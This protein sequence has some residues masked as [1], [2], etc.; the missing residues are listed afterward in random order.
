MALADHPLL[1]AAARVSG[2]VQH[3]IDLRLPKM[4][5]GAIVRSRMPHARIT[6]VDTARAQRIP[7][8][9]AVVVVA[10][11]RVRYVGDPVTVIAAEDIETAHEAA[12]AIEIGY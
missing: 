2:R 3:L 11:E 4:L 5:V 8:V 6:H 9:R 1:D 12:A 10:R 7:G